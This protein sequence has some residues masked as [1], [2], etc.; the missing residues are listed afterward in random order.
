[1]NMQKQNTRA[2][3]GIALIAVGLLFLLDE[4]S[5]F[6]IREEMI[7][8]IIFAIAGLALLS[9]YNTDKLTWKLVLG[10]IA[11]FIGFVTFVES[12][13][14][15]SHDYLGG[16]ILWVLAAGFLAVYAKN[17][18]NWWGII[19]GGILLTTGLMVMLEEAFWG[20]RYY[21]HVVFFIGVALTFGYL[22]KI[23]DAENRLE[24]AKWPAGVGL[25]I[26]GISFLNEFFYN[27]EEFVAPLALILVG[28]FLIT[29][30]FYRRKGRQ[31]GT[32]IPTT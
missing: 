2:W 30:S 19:P 10:L 3:F 22:Y 17:K 20:F 18:K 7:V 16:L 14:I 27:F 6:Y 9:A 29:R 21:S 12:T 31:N 5:I 4:L 28:V 23:R 25:G 32:Q 11:L 24:W 8:S 1:M 15:I 26:A 13:R